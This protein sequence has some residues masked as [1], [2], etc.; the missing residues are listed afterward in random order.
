MT[1][2]RLT[3]PPIFK[4]DLTINNNKVRQLLLTEESA[5]F[6]Y[7]DFNQDRVLGYIIQRDGEQ[8]PILLIKNNARVPEQFSHVLKINGDI[9]DEGAHLKWL[10]HPAIT[11]EEYLLDQENQEVLRSWENNFNFKYELTHNAQI[12]QYGLRAPQIGAIHSVLSH[13]VLSEKPATVVMPTGTGKTETMI[14]ILVAKQCAKLLVVVPT[15]PLRTQIANKFLS[16]G[17]LKNFG[18]IGESAL[19]P[20]VGLMMHRPRSL[21]EVDSLFNR[22]NVVVTTMSI[23]GG[24]SD[25]MQERIAEK[26]SHLFID[27]AHHIAAPTWASFR[28]KFSVRN[29]IQFTATPFRNDGKHVDG[30]IIFNYPLEK[31]QKEGYFK[32]INFYP[33]MEFSEEMSDRSIAEIAV[34]RLRD[35]LQEGNDHLLMARVNSITRTEEIL[36]IYNAYQEYNPVVI[37]SKLRP[38]EKKEALEK[39]FSRQSRI[40]I[41]VDMLGEGFDLPQL[42]IAAMHDIHKSLGITLQFTGRFTRTTANIGEA[43]MVANIAFQDVTNQLKSLYSE[44]ADWNVLLKNSSTGAIRAEIEYSEF[45]SGFRT[46]L[47]E[48]IPIQNIY[49]K[50]STVVYKTNSQT[51]HPE[52]ILNVLPRDQEV[53]YTVH[54]ERKILIAVMKSMVPVSWGD[55]REISNI[56]WDI[57]IAYFDTAKGLLYIN[58]TLKGVHQQLAEEL[59]QNTEIIKGENIFKT[60]YGLNRIILQNVGLNDAFNGPISFRMYTGVDIAQGLSDAQKRNTFKSN[61]FGLGFE[62]GEKTS[63]GCSY[64]G[65]IWSRRIATISDWCSWCDAVGV[66]ITND[67]INVDTLLQGVLKPVLIRQRPALMPI[68]IEWPASFAIENETI[69]YV[70]VNGTNYPLYESELQ[71]V[72][73]SI[74]GNIK[75]KLKTINY[76]GTFELRFDPSVDEGRNYN[77]FQNGTVPIEIKKGS[78]RRCLTEWFNE[79]A[80]IIR[81]HDGSYMA[82]NYFVNPNRDNYLPFNLDNITGWDWNDVDITKESQNEEKRNDSIQ[83]SLIQRLL[84]GDYDIIFDDDNAGEAADVVTFKVSDSKIHV[85]FFHCKFSHGSTPGARV[86]DLYEV[87]GQ[88]Q[89]SIHWKDSIDALLKH[90]EKREST[91]LRDGRVSRFEKGD[92]KKITEIKKMARF[93]P[94][95]LSI[96]IVQPGLSKQA[97]SEGQLEI[98]SATDNYLRETYGIP[99]KVISSE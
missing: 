11:G 9:T 29:I 34:E 32:K 5:V 48:Q 73:P 41:C 16:F 28:D 10:K 31:A 78:N 8:Q 69:I 21:E 39:L 35:D 63:V 18:V 62:N 97:V 40:V 24:I 92:L 95:Y 49:P 46:G 7:Q 81:F 67:T 4:F 22:C 85:E 91:R 64:R 36:P 42:K 90:L 99:L 47:I 79:E 45:L 54:S 89:K 3:L 88:A 19:Y 87:C 12:T 60:F 77:Y 65:K 74:D 15:D 33:V 93:F 96:F 13:W 58:S 30:K 6:T 82:N 20:V 80:P 52:R 50:M 70:S 57:Y 43:S 25:E 83:Y 55:I 2:I 53:L 98:L 1:T 86:A 84:N 51:W 26:C 72:D 14:G 94:F 75:F 68:A 76:E 27:E 38:S 56:S 17:I 71:L 23:V 37:H 66:K 61:I 59:V 44:D